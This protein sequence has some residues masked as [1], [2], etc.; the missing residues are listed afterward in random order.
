MFIL[1]NREKQVIN[2][3]DLCDILLYL[4][5]LSDMQFDPEV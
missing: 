2:A 3:L 1:R 5:K 4:P